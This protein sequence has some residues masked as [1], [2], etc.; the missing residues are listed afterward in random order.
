[1][2]QTYTHLVPW[3]VDSLCASQ[4][5]L[6]WTDQGHLA[7]ADASGDRTEPGATRLMKVARWFGTPFNAWYVG[8]IVQINKRRTKQDNVSAEFN[9]ETYGTTWG[10]WPAASETYGADRKCQ[11]GAPEPNPHRS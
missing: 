10:H 9:D 8:K 6:G 7:R 4:V 1:M 3:G 2:Q 11:V 5:K